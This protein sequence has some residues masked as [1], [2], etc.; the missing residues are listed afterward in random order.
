VRA[1]VLVLALL[2]VAGCRA[3]DR[4]YQ[5]SDGREVR[6]LDPAPYRIAVAPVES[7]GWLDGQRKGEEPYWF[8]LDGPGLQKLFVAL[9]SEDP[10]PAKAYHLESQRT[11]NSVVAL[12][13]HDPGGI[14]EEAQRRGADLVVVPRLVEPPRFAFDKHVRTAASV[15]WWLCTWVGG[16]FVQDKR[17]D[18]HMTID[19]DVVN[20]EDGTTVETFTATSNVM[21]LT[22]WE[23]QDHRFGAG[24]AMS[25]ILPPQLTV[26]QHAKVSE[27]LTLLVS[28]RFAA[29]FTGYLKEDFAQR[30]RSLLGAVRAV[31][32]HSGSDVGNVLP[33][34]ADIIADQPI[35]HVAL[36]LNGD[37]KPVFEIKEGAASLEVARQAAGRY[38]RVAVAEADGD[39]APRPVRIPLAPGR[40]EVR[41]EYAVLGRYASR[42]F[43]YWNR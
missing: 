43:V 3:V 29:R 40:N 10:A 4:A 18:A 34:S 22:L 21:D 13:E 17:Y 25:L 31:Y 19:F 5:T 26:E 8:T 11:A 7:E 33:L 16:L 6:S 36:Y 27:A 41:L 30:E 2:A 15:A 12:E 1:S 32:P 28:S 14:L 23:R 42:T 9:M 35:T 24:V 20:A 38:F 39:G 37:R